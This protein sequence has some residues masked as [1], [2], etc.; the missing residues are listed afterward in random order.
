MASSCLRKAMERYVPAPVAQAAKQ[1]FSA[2]DASW[3][4]AKV[5]TTSA[6]RCRRDTPAIYEYLDR[7]TVHGLIDEHLSG[8]ANHRLLIWSLLSVE[9]WCRNVPARQ[10]ASARR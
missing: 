5:S 2:P 10:R 7:A 8:R 9:Q 1:G 3:F 6:E 4:R